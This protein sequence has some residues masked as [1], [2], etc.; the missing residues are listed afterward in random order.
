VAIF[1][2]SGCIQF[3]AAQE[4]VLL[5]DNQKVRGGFSHITGAA[6][7]PKERWLR[8]GWQKSFA[9]FG[10]TKD[11]DV[12]P[13]ST[14]LMRMPVLGRLYITQEIRWTESL[15][16]V[17]L[18]DWFLA[19]LFAVMPARTFY[20]WRRSRRWRREGLCESCGYDLRVAGERCPECGN[21]ISTA[22]GETPVL[23]KTS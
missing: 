4:A 8:L 11:W 7:H 16:A 21:V 5:P 10:I 19:L 23:R 14:Q 3:A 6:M 18:P 12:A 2:G 15:K 20:L 17:W 1:S 9:G 22:T 13:S